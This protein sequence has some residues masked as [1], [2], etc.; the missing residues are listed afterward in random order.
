[1][2]QNVLSDENADMASECATSAQDYSKLHFA[3]VLN[4]VVIVREKS[5]SQK[6]CCTL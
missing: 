4:P 2:A 6:G 3:E 1:M 5:I